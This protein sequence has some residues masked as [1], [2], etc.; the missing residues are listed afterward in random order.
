MR[1]LVHE[2]FHIGH[3]YQHIHHLLPTLIDVVDEVV[4]AITARGRKTIEFTS[5]IEP[6]ANR[7]TI[8][9]DLPWEDQG[10]GTYGRFKL[11][12]NLYNT[13]QRIKPDYVL[14]P[15]ADG[16]TSAMGILHLLGNNLPKNVEA[17][18]GIC[19]GL[20]DHSIFTVR[21]RLKKFLH[22][23]TFSWSSWIRIHFLN[24]ALYESIQSRNS[25]LNNR[26]KMLPCPIPT[27]PR[28]DKVESRKLLGIPEDGHYVGV[29]G[30]LDQ[31]KAIDKLLNSFRA[32]TLRKN[33]RILLAGHL[34]KV[35][36]QLIEHEYMDLVK[37][38]RIVLLDHYLN[39]NEFALT[40]SAVDVVC[41]PLPYFGQLSSILLKSVAAG[42]P[43]LANDFGW[44]R[45]IIK[46]FQLGW[47]CDVLNREAFTRSLQI[48]FEQCGEY[49]ESEATRRLL[50]FHAPK[51]FAESWVARL[52]EITEQPALTPIR[53]WDWVLESTSME[54]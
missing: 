26:A 7:I 43:V 19:Y 23:T 45:M 8:D 28:R 21:D 54:R 4:L 18:A 25:S 16:Q 5:L 41:T 24:A 11:Y 51:N 46:R 52:R 14:V 15:S 32:A 36:R 50:E 1:V 2:Q 3:F 34:D 29:I 9:S 37:Q 6:F 12:Y 47:T 49:R 40:F 31:R 30:V 42:R 22:H 39:E 33:D 44:C 13:I 38:E 17:E 35:F 27:Y 10:V 48:A 53:T 20:D